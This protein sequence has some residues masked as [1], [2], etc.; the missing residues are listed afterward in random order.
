MRQ[1]IATTILIGGALLPVPT[2]ADLIAYFPL[3]GDTNDASGNGNNGTNFFGGTYSSDVPPQ[4]GGGTALDMMGVAGQ[5]IA[6][7]EAPHDPSLDAVDEVSVT[8]WINPNDLDTFYFIAVKGPTGSA[9]DNWPGNYEFRINPGAGT[10]QFLHQTSEA[11]TLSI[12]NSE[13]NV[14]PGEWTHIAVTAA[15]GGN[16][17]F[18]VNGVQSGAFPQE[19]DFG[20]LNENSLFVGTRK[21]S[22]SSF[23]GRLDEVAVYNEELTQLQIDDIV[24][25][26]PLGYLGCGVLGDVNG[27]EQADLDD[28]AIIS[29]NMGLNP[30]TLEQGNANR[31]DG[32]EMLDFRLWKS[33]RTDIAAGQHAVPEPT[34]LALLVL[35]AAGWLARRRRI[36]KQVTK[37]TKLPHHSRAGMPSNWDSTPVENRRF[38]A[39]QPHQAQRKAPRGSQ[40]DDLRRYSGATSVWL[41][42]LSRKSAGCYRPNPGRFGA[43][44]E[45]AAERHSSLTG[46]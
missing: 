18:Y 3:D 45:W 10:P 27:D 5:M 46:T 23:S 37:A 26:G 25:C 21:D 6:G 40:N 17:T 44:L 16:V 12:Y 11:A 43:D 13:T 14:V 2:H 22:F 30:A 7:F 24:F 9:P 33:N 39:F 8:A 4:V 32:V 28:F 31:R 35:G 20:F 34:A 15:A 38:R 41:S 19:G 29:G 1:L 42:S 36:G